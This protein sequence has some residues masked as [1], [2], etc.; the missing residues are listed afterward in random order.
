VLL[1][2]L[3]SGACHAQAVLYSS[4]WANAPSTRFEVVGKAGSFYWAQTS[5]KNSNP[6]RAIAPWIPDI[7]FSFDVYDARLNRVHTIPNPISDTVLKQYLIAGTH[8][9]DQLLITKSQDKTGVLIKRFSP[10][11]RFASNVVSLP[12][13]PGNTTANDFLLVRSPCQDKLLLLAFEPVTESAPRL[14]VFLF[15]AD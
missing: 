10:D 5:R 12:N 14:H 8:Y 1:C 11:G 9:F 4:V 2:G 6:K 15:N 7:D 13:V 3:V